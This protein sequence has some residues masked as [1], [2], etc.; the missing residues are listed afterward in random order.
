M[1]VGRQENPNTHQWTNLEAVFSRKS[2][3]QLGDAT[4]AELLKRCFLC[5]PYLD[6]INSQLIRVKWSE[7]VGK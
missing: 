5:G 1:L 7:L 2:V 4:I 3:R 6:V